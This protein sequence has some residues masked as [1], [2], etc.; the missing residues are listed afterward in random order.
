MTVRTSKVLLVFWLA[1]GAAAPFALVVT[2]NILVLWITGLLALIWNRVDSRARAYRMTLKAP[3]GASFSL[4][5]GKGARGG[6]PSSSS[7]R[8]G[9][10]S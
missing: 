7:V 9:K 10:D 6:R 4:D 1:L 3:G 2:D 8:D 5:A